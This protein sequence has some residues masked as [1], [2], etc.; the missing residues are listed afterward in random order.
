MVHRQGIRLIIALVIAL[1]LASDARETN[2]RPNDLSG[3]SVVPVARTTPVDF[4]TDDRPLLFLPGGSPLLDVLIPSHGT[5]ALVSQDAMV[6]GIAIP[7]RAPARMLPLRP[8]H[9]RVVS[10][11][12][13]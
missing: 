1:G 12:P 8:N 9:L 2:A 11:P 7:E 6:P 13:R 10:P 4:P 3:S 5:S